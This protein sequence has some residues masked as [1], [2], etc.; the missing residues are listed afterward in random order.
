MIRDV[1]ES[2]SVFDHFRNE[3]S[4]CRKGS[5]ILS[6]DEVA[7]EGLTGIDLTP[8][9]SRGNARSSDRHAQI[10]RSILFK[11]GLWVIASPNQSGAQDQCG[12]D[13][14]G[15]QRAHEHRSLVGPRCK[16]W[17]KIR[18]SVLYS[19]VPQVLRTDGL[20]PTMP[21]FIRSST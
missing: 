12:C 9:W 19:G 1:A 18:L 7:R 14:A 16:D 4:S 21:E 17:T 20:N 6:G 15:M 8:F 5:G 13:S 11:V 10:K 2:C 3:R